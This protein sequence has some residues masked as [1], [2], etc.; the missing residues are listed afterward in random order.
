MCFPRALC[1]IT[2]YG[3]TAD[4]E[5]SYMARIM[6]ISVIPLIIIQIP[7]IFHFSSSG[8]R[9]LIIITL[10]ISVSFLLGYFLYQV[11]HLDHIVAT[12]CNIVKAIFLHFLNY[13]AF[14][15]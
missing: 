2:D 1:F 5:T 12:P 11:Y 7:T 14:P 3:I 15:R 6:L 13:V 9:I 8:E 10:V 4:V